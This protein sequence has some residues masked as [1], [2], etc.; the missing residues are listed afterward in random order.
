MKKPFKY[1]VFCELTHEVLYETNQEPSL[2]ELQTWQLTTKKGQP[3]M[4]LKQTRTAYLDTRYE[5]KI[6]LYNYF[7]YT[8]QGLPIPKFSPFEGTEI[9]KTIPILNF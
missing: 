6:R 5:A 8:K 4:E 1:T 2:R 7:T 9:G 3:C